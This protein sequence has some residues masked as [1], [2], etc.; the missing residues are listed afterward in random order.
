ML[1]EDK[2]PTMRRFLSTDELTLLLDDVKYKDGWQINVYEGVHGQM[3]RVFYVTQDSYDHTK[4]WPNDLRV[5]LPPF[6]N[7]W[8]FFDFLAWRLK[9]QEIHESQEF[10]FVE[11]KPY[12]DPHAEYADRDL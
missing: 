5:P 7:A 4:S 11:G 1:N 3:L 9:R 12:D 2:G 6:R 10:F 8:Q